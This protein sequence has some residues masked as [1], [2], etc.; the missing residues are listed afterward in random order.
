MFRFF[1]PKLIILLVIVLIAGVVGLGIYLNQ[2]EIATAT[3][4]GGAV[5]DFFE[6][7]EIAPLTKI[8]NKGSIELSA[9]EITSD[10]E[11]VFGEDFE[12]KGKIYFS[13]SKN[14]MM[15]DNFYLNLNGSAWGGD[16]YISPDKSYIKETEKVDA[17]IGIVKG[18]YAED[19]E[20]SIFAF[21]SG[22]DYAIEDEET[23]DT[24]MQI[25]E[26]IDAL[27]DEKM[28]KDAKKIAKKYFKEFWKMLCEYSQVGMKIA[29]VELNDGVTYAKV[30]NVK[31][32][33][34]TLANVMEKYC[35]YLEE[36]EDVIKFIEKYEGDLYDIVTKYVELEEISLADLYWESISELNDNMDDICEEILESEYNYELEL[37]TNIVTTKLMKL[38]AYADSERIV[39]LDVGSKGI[40]KSE[41]I[42]IELEDTK[43][44]YE[45]SKY[46]K[47]INVNMNINGEEVLKYKFNKNKDEYSFRI[48]NRIEFG[49]TITSKFGKTTLTVENIAVTDSDTDVK[50]KYEADIVLVFDKSDKIPKADKDFDR[51]SDYSQEDIEDIISRI[52]E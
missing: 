8:F 18:E 31:I 12:A 28:A 13:S 44:S 34:E 10:G 22:S 14:A 27:E 39:T 29:K 35:A 26:Y 16:M 11:A 40:K 5:E 38:T 25:L 30:I 52:T 41:K 17:S 42:T 21:D 4:I 1:N 45:V 51:I 24:I 36:D 19:F 32:N 20:D 50:T 2:P 23:Y 46:S 15:V 49:G 48:L 47:L 43:V 33:S 6:R 7:D 3:A 37:V 9:S